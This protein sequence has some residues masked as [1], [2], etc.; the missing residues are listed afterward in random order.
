MSV[1]QLFE[2]ETIS[3]FKYLAYGL[4][5]ALMLGG[6]EAPKVALQARDILNA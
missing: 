4:T 1:E 6:R 3:R 5:K 2:I